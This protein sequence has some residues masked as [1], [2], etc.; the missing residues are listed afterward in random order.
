MAVASSAFLTSNETR[1]GSPTT[2]RVGLSIT[3]TLGAALSTRNA[4][5]SDA[6]VPSSPVTST[7]NR[8]SPALDGTQRTAPRPLVI[9]IRPR[10]L[11]VS[12]V[13]VRISRFAFAT[14]KDSSTGSPTTTGSV[15][16]TDDDL[17]RLVQ[18]LSHGTLDVR[19]EARPAVQERGHP[20]QARRA[21]SSRTLVQA[22]DLD[23]PLAE[24][25]ADVVPEQDRVERGLVQV[26]DLE[27][28]QSQQ[29]ADARRREDQPTDLGGAQGDR[30]ARKAPAASRARPVRR[31][32]SH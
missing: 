7:R 3:R 24:G 9:S 31:R 12:D 10:W 4:T 14:W 2:A 17:R 5:L 29:V 23:D 15:G 30:V 18:R 32:S 20:D 21:G 27:V 26:T 6:T 13:R 25:T 19:P 28:P 11:P 8:N 22:L 1:R 16:A